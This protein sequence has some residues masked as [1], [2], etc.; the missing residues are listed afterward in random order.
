MT[1]RI[2]EDAT[3][4]H[5]IETLQPI[6]SGVGRQVATTSSSD[7]SEQ[8]RLVQ[9]VPAAS[10]VY[11][12]ELLIRE[13][14]RVRDLDAAGSA[15]CLSDDLE[16][17]IDLSWEHL[18]NVPWQD[19]QPSWRTLHSCACI[20]VAVHH[21]LSKAVNDAYRSL[22]MAAIMGGP[23]HKSVISTLFTSM[24]DQATA[25]AEEKTVVTKLPITDSAIATQVP[26][27][28]SDDLP[29]PKK[30]MKK[31]E[32]QNTSDQPQKVTAHA[33]QTTHCGAHCLGKVPILSLPS[34]KDFVQ[35]VMKQAQPVIIRGGCKHWPAFR[36]WQD[37]A[38]LSQVAGHRTV[39]VELGRSYTS[40]DW[41]QTLMT[42]DRFLNEHIRQSGKQTGYL[43]QH[44][45]FEQ[46]PDLA[47]DIITPDYCAL[48]LPGS[49]E[50]DLNG[51][52]RVW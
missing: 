36:R 9:S 19:V 17:C 25:S 4:A 48:S 20:I 13:L 10:V 50:R 35:R 39:P 47:K 6:R 14:Q 18:H 40:E 12:S 29:N 52:V 5:L 31:S 32:P 21:F 45:L 38:Y 27:D 26:V 44:N 42:F 41:G 2:L 28:D 23:I 43:A 37:L 8:P 49:C 11:V 33:T 16:I 7:G 1:A 15:G 51:E 30:K 34:M 46:V 3:F 22:D 24:R